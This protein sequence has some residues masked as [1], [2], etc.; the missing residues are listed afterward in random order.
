GDNRRLDRGIRSAGT[1]RHVKPELVAVA[2]GA[3]DVAARKLHRMKPRKLEIHRRP[4]VRRPPAGGGEAH[5]TASAGQE[6]TPSHHE[7]A[8]CVVFPVLIDSRAPEA[9]GNSSDVKALTKRSRKSSIGH[10]GVASS[11]WRPRA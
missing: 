8:H 5:T 6:C 4:G 10:T 7:L 9:G 2:L 3:C 1:E 11:G